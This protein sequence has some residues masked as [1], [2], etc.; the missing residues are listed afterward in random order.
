MVS[1][2]FGDLLKRARRHMCISRE[3]LARR[4]KV[5]TRLVAEVERGQRPNVSLESA[6][7]LLNLVGVTIAARAPDGATAEIG[8]AD[9]AA[10]Q[11]GARASL[12]RRTWTGRHVPLRNESTAPDS[13]RTHVERLSAA[14]RISRQAFA[15][16]KAPAKR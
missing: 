7:K 1:P 8:D 16:S 3:E 14:S 13:G 2:A 9:S 12:R 6:M 5:S 10:V 15:M 4:G 11:R